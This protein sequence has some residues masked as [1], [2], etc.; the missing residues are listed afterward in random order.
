MKLFETVKFTPEVF[1]IY[2]FVYFAFEV[3]VNSFVS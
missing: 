3:G 1:E 2:I